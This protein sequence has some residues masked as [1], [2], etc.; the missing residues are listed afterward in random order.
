MNRNRKV[1]VAALTLTAG[2]MIGN[3]GMSVS[4]TPLAGATAM[5]STTEASAEVTSNSTLSG[6]NLAL[7]DMV[8]EASAKADE[9]VTEKETTAVAESKEAE[10]DSKFNHL[11]VG[12][13]KDYANIRKHA[14]ASSKLVGH[15]SDGDLCTV[16]K[17]K[18]SWYK[19]ESGKVT[20][21][22][23]A[24]YLTVGSEK[25]VKKASRVIAKVQTQTLK[26]R[27]KASTKAEVLDLAAKGDTLVVKDYNSE[28]A[29]DGWIKIKAGDRTG[30]VST[31]YVRLTR[32]YHYAESI[33]S[34]LAKLEA[35]RAEEQAA[36]NA[37]ENTSN[38]SSTSN[39]SSSSNRSNNQSNDSNNSN[40][41]SSRDYDAPDS[42]NG[43]AVARFATQFVG[44]PYVW[45]G[46]SLTNGA[47]CSGFVMAVYSHFG[48]SL[49]HSSSSDRS[50]GV[51][52]SQSNMQAG[53]IVCYS[54]HVA[55]Y[56]GG[57]QI[58]HASNARDGIKISNANYRNILAVRR[59]L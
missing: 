32:S 35:E 42:R 51:A 54:G 58:V 25:A 59:V 52:V 11:A 53:D 7:A 56:I 44:N 12:H 26:I 47:D 50:V 28:D 22:V 6:V 36:E 33:E 9:A 24:D 13:V 1:Q 17:K 57:G 43:G 31:D 20:G 18:G 38:N 14:S 10:Q 16:L 49:P 27:A 39:G 37:L 5:V 3:A 45:G 55:I 41:S 46:S 19:V 2:V 21:Y 29:K 48:K 23:K 8:T 15:L 40:N 30:Y 34:I 4:A